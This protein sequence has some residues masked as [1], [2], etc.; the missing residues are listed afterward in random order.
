MTNKQRFIL[1]L[2]EK[3]IYAKFMASCMRVSKVTKHDFYEEL[4][5]IFCDMENPFLY[6]SIMDFPYTFS[7]SSKSTFEKIEHEWKIIW[8]EKVE[9]VFCAFLKENNVYE[10]FLNQ[11]HRNFQNYLTA[12]SPSLY[13]TIAFDWRSTTEGEDFWRRISSKWRDIEKIQHYP[14]TEF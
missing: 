5:I 10:T 2:K 14:N 9:N 6:F 13:I 4:K 7:F 8:K 1:F 11:I 3:N 12:T